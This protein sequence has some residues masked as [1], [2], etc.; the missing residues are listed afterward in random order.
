MPTPMFTHALV[1]NTRFILWVSSRL[2]AC[3]DNFFHSVHLQVLTA[4]CGVFIDGF[5]GFP[6]CGVL[7]LLLFFLPPVVTGVANFIAY[8]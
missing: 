6:A 8:K 7:N 5:K 1:N 4:D 2:F 3:L